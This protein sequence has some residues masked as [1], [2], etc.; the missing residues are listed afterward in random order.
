LPEGF[1]QILKDFTREVLR[2]QTDDINKFAY[3]YFTEA[4]RRR[5]SPSGTGLKVCTLFEVEVAPEIFSL[6]S[7]VKWRSLLV[8]ICGWLWC[9]P[10]LQNSEPQSQAQ[11]LLES[12]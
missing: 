9:G 11:R 12:R 1:P 2:S 7:G 6:R 8:F 4:I 10:T 5:D 3:E